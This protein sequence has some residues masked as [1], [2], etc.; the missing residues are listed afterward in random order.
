MAGVVEK[1]AAGELLLSETLYDYVDFDM[2]IPEIICGLCT[3]PL[4]D[5]RVLVCCDNVYCYQCLDGLA[6]HKCPFC[7]DQPF[8][9]AVELPKLAIKVLLKRL[10]DLAVFC[11]QKHA[12]CP[13]TGP[14]CGLSQHVETACA[15]QPC[16][17][18]G[19][20]CVWRGKMTA[21]EAHTASDC[22]YVAAPCPH[23]EHGC[24]FV[25]LRGDM[26]AHSTN[27]EQCNVL[28][29]AVELE[30]QREAERAAEAE[31]LRLAEVQRHRALLRE[32]LNPSLT[33]M[34]TF[35]V[36][37]RSF[38]VG[39][40]IFAKCGTSLL[41]EIVLTDEAASLKLTDAG[42][43]ILDIDADAFDAV[44]AWLTFDVLPENIRDYSMLLETARF[45]ELGGLLAALGDDVAVIQVGGETGQ[46]RKVSQAL[47]SR[48]TKTNSCALGGRL[49]LPFCKLDG[50]DMSGLRLE[51][52]LFCLSSLRGVV[53][54]GA[55]FARGDFRGCHF[56]EAQLSVA[57]F[58]GADLSRANFSGANVSG[59]NFSNANLQGTNFGGMT[60]RATWS[61]CCSACRSNPCC[62][63]GHSGLASH[64]CWRR[65][66]CSLTRTRP[67]KTL[68]LRLRE[69]PLPARLTA[70]RASAACVAATRGCHWLVCA[71]PFYP[72]FIYYF[73]LLGVRR[74]F[75]ATPSR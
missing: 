32:K 31:A 40:Q 51:S 15:C 3:N 47:F 45:L 28:Q 13:W 1:A 63:R 38:T 65:L 19:A 70:T 23:A 42:E 24:D 25:G 50:L 66:A 21:V 58:T 74:P 41:G 52:A 2:A 14:R 67:R 16:I 22:A 68:S 54:V 10:D 57:D 39:K 69:A 46:L 11:S 12:S 20:G 7:P 29:R 27:P 75:P 60:T 4:V 35:S 36:R 6:H 18:A 30:A 53:A 9:A 8:G 56:N 49:S 48:L 59:A 73:L 26:A 55:T 61:R 5:P 44:V 33:Q 37:G 71:T 64:C 17:H 34:V 72:I 62:S 43:I